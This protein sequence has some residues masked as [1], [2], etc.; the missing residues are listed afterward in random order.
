MVL[1]KTGRVCRRQP[2][3]LTY[4]SWGFFFIFNYMLYRFLFYC[5]IFFNIYLT[6]SQELIEI[7]S[8]N[9]DI[10]RPYSITLNNIGDPVLLLNLLS[11]ET[12]LSL[13]HYSKISREASYA[14]NY[15]QFQTDSIYSHVL[16]Q[17]A[18]NSGGLLK[19]FLTRPIGKFLKLNFSYNHLT[20]Q[21]FYANQDNK[22]SS[23]YFSFN[24]LSVEKPYSYKFSFFSNNGNYYNHG[25]V[26]YDSLLSLDLMNTYLN[27]S[28]TN[29]KNRLLDFQHNYYIRSD[30]KLKHTI[31]FE[32]FNR[33]YTDEDPSSFHYSVTP[34]YYS[35]DEDSDYSISSFYSRV[36]NSVSLSTKN[37]KFQL[38]HNYYNTDNLILNKTGDL[39]IVLSSTDS[40]RADNN[41]NFTINFCPLGYNQNNYIADLV[42]YKKNKNV[43]YD[44]NF[45]LKSKNPHFFTPHYNTSFSFDWDSFS[46]IRHVSLM[47]KSSFVH[48]KISIS[49]SLN[50]YTNYLYFNEFVSPVQL[51]D[52]MLYFNV[53]LNKTWLLNNFYFRSNLLI[54]KNNNDL[55]SIPDI[56]LEQEI[57]YQHIIRNNIK[58]LSSIDFNIFSKYYVSSYFPLTD[59]FFLQLEEKRGMVPLVSANLEICKDNF[60]IGCVFNNISMSLFEGEYLIKDYPLLPPTLQLLIKWQFL[61]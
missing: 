19:T 32:F 8:L 28:Q 34:L 9:L 51:Q 48:S 26:I 58:I 2:S 56:I 25:G 38:N 30:L 35:I 16:Y 6:S 60:S 36:H 24:H 14:E 4:L 50:H 53:I 40:F 41:I 37:L 57:Q 21:G 27:S 47:L 13:T 23:L 45:L 15:A 61:N 42:Y 10:H 17:T 12:D 3:A 22:Y 20:S 11:N 54:Q 59:V 1:G 5:I 46:P 52:N 49:S 33:D 18:Y 31:L 44:F 43:I 39:D 29:I 7:D 55:V